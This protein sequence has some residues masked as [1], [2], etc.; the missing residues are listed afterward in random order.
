MNKFPK[1]FI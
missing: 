1:Y